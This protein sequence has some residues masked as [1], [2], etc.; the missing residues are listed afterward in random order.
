MG[1]GWLTMT[2]LASLLLLL[3]PAARGGVHYSGD[4]F[5][6]LPA[7]W[8]GFLPDLRQLRTPAGP[9]HARYLA[10]L[11]RLRAVAAPSADQLAD[12]GALHLRLD[13]PADALAVLRPAAR[14]FPD[15]FR[16]AAHLGT[17][18]NRLGDL[19][20]AAEA[21]DDAV[22]LATPEHQPLEELH[23]T[24]V[25]L[26]LTER[27]TDAPDK[28][29]ADP[30]PAAAVARVQELLLSLPADGRLLWLLAELAVAAGDVRPAAA[31]L[32][33]CVTE[34]GMGSAKLRDR[35]QAVRQLADAAER[36]GHATVSRIPFR[37]PRAFARLIDPALLPAVTTGVNPLSWAVLGETE[38]D[39]RG[40][41]TFLAHLEKLDGRRVE[42]AGHATP[43]GTGEATV[44][45]FLLT[46]AAVGCWFCEVPGPTQVVRVELPDGVSVAAPRGAVR[47]TGVLRLNRTDP[48]GLPVRVEEARVRA[49]D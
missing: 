3:A 25:R 16:V 41:P 34:F 46:E 8:N 1:F 30:P 10:D 27:T 33:G 37:S 2:R 45:A 32:D 47:V 18:W 31:M 20:R 4:Q 7:R 5:R 26:R 21:L 23:R 40:R 13:R 39:G 11:A 24:L 48:E 22:R 15:H 9:L 35:R 19:P 43:V 36:Q 44:G 29:F 14:R 49:A 6:P 42:V 28:L 12:L 17:A 38:I